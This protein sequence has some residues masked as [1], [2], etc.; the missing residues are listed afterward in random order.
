M[1]VLSQRWIPA[2]VSSLLLLC[3]AA[4]DAQQAA[5]GGAA[6]PASSPPP[7]GLNRP[8]LN[9]QRIDELSHTHDGD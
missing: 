1:S 8:G 6:P 3:T 5:S 2:L 9:Q 4:A 7:G